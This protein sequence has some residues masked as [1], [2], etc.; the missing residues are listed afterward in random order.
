MLALP[1]HLS[2]YFVEPATQF[3]PLCTNHVQIKLRGCKRGSCSCADAFSAFFL[4]ELQPLGITPGKNFYAGLFSD[5]ELL[6]FLLRQGIQRPTVHARIGGY[7]H[8]T[9]VQS[10]PHGI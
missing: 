3:W 2:A 1:V 8:P 9:S 10:H 5:G 4:G 6:V 7:L